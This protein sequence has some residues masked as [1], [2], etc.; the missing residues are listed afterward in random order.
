MTRLAVGLTILVFTGGLAA[1]LVFSVAE[2]GTFGP[3]EAVTV[4]ILLLF[5]LAG[6][7]VLRRG[8]D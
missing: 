3:L 5:L 1:L 4:L 6:V 7:G 2:S 8:T